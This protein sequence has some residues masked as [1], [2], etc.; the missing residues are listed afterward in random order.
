[1]KTMTEISFV[2]LMTFICAY[3]DMRRRKVYNVILIFFL[4]G[5]VVIQAVLEH[6]VDFSALGLLVPFALH[7]LPFMLRLISAGDV[8]LFMVLGAVGGLSFVI[9]IMVMTYC[10]AGFLALCILLRRKILMSRMKR[11][12]VYFKTLELV[13]AFVPYEVEQSPSLAF[14]LALAV[15]LAVL[16]QLIMR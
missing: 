12:F 8:K 16:I 11:L 6:H 14:P 13:G 1:M 3:T 2:V 4:V 5:M 9:D 15:H 10:I 7:F